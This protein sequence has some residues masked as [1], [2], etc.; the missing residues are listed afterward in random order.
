MKR[1]RGSSYIRGPK[2]EP[3]ISGASAEAAS[4][5]LPFS[6]Q[7]TQLGP[8]SRSLL[9]SSLGSQLGKKMCTGLREPTQGV[10]VGGE[11]KEVSVT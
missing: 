8:H 9:R 10:C 3:F 2:R 5:S 11:D 4:F 1:L 6:G 7:R